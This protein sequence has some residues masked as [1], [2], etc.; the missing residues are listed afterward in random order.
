MTLAIVKITLAL[1]KKRHC[2][3]EGKKLILFVK[4]GIEPS[5]PT[6]LAIRS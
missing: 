2:I 1:V 6:R 5:T 3:R 4:T